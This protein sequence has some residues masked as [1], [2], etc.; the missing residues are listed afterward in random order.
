MLRFICLGHQIVST[1]LVHL[2]HHIHDLVVEYCTDVDLSEFIMHAHKIGKA[3]DIIKKGE[4][5]CTGYLH[6]RFAVAPNE[7]FYM[8]RMSQ[9]RRV[10][11]PGSIIDP[12]NPDKKQIDKVVASLPEDKNNPPHGKKQEKKKRN[13]SKNKRNEIK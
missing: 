5:I 3:I 12:K 10:Q 6:Q 11:K 13:K 9:D 8:D 7:V 4:V 1:A 2:V